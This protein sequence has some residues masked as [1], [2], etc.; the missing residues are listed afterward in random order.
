MYCGCSK[1]EILKYLKLSL[2]NNRMK[3]LSRVVHTLRRQCQAG[4][5]ENKIIC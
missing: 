2:R 1:K 3:A 5:R 4:K